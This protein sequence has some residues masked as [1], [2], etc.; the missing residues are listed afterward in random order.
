[1]RETLFFIASI[2]GAAVLTALAVLVPPESLL[3]KVML[4]GGIVTLILCA[5][6]LLIDIVRRRIIKAVPPSGR[7]EICCKPGAPYGVS[8]ISHGHILS[9]VRIGLKNSGERPVSN[10]KVFIDKIAPLPD[11]AGGLPILLEGDGFMLRPDDPETLVDIAA[12]WDHLSK[13]RFQA[14]HGL[15]AETL[16]YLDDRTE[17]SIVIK[18]EATECQK[19]ALFKMW[20]DESKKLRLQY[21]ADV[22]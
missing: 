2:A 5:V 16:N 17:R 22:A 7:I 10:C 12:H 15:F 20:T 3:W 6:I 11:L 19:S 13:Y 14:P 8:E 21:V 9:T 18:I 4:Y 1:V